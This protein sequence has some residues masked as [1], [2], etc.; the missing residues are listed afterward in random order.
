MSELSTQVDS[1]NETVDGLNE[2]VDGLNSQLSS[3]DSFISAV[4]SQGIFLKVDS[5]YNAGSG[6]DLISDYLY[7]DSMRYM[8]FDCSFY[9]T[10]DFSYYS[11][12]EITVRVYKPDGYLDQGSNSP[13]GASFTFT[14]DS[15]T[16]SIGWGNASTSTFSSGLYVAQFLYNDEIIGSTSLTI[17]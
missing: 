7:S 2:T 9:C 12:D 11:G 17:Y 1:L 15:E 8:Y 14:L 5:V 6:G 10:G 4:C 3:R 16:K 13:S